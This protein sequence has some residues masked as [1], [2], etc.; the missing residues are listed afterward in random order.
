M[1]ANDANKIIHKEISYKINGVLFKEFLT[2]EQIL[3]IL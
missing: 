1:G 3:L 2:E